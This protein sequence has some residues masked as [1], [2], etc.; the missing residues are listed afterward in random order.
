MVEGVGGVGDRREGVDDGFKEG[1][2][3]GVGGVGDRREGVDDGFKE[4]MVEGFRV[5][6]DR[7]EG[8]DDGFK[9]GM[10]EGIGGFGDR[11]EGVDDGFKE[12]IVEGVGGV[13]DRREGVD[14]GFK[15]GMVEGSGCSCT[16]GTVVSEE[17]EGDNEGSELISTVVALGVGANDNDGMKEGGDE[18][19]NVGA[20][21]CDS[22]LVGD[23]DGDIDD[24]PGF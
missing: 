23:S 4:G 18:G 3:E 19:V 8:V 2:V 24:C 22:L 14:D 16:E 12:G 15:E 5:V 1:M 20:S 17:V 21:S 7:R 10:V 9:E 6:G 13:G 11:R